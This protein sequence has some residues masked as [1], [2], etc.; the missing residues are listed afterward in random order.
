MSISIHS[1]Y[2]EVYPTS[3]VEE[4][5]DYLKKRENDRIEFQTSSPGVRCPFD[6]CAM[7]FTTQTPTEIIVKYDT[8]CKQCSDTID[9]DS[10][11]FLKICALDKFLG[12]IQ[13]AI[14]SKQKGY[15]KLSMEELL[16][17]ANDLYDYAR[18]MRRCET[19]FDWRG[20]AVPQGLLNSISENDEEQKA[21]EFE[22][23][24]RR[25]L[26]KIPEEITS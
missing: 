22:L 17:E 12:L 23:A 18:Y 5:Q 15:D 9:I 4:L 24:Y 11:P 8:L 20:D 14:L 21:L 1:F 16:N 25:L 3:S 26:N 10:D 13:S 2:T 7:I 6:C 19:D